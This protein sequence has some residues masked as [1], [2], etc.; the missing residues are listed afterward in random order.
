M[1]VV[2]VNGDVAATVLSSQNRRAEIVSDKVVK[3]HVSK[4]A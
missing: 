4:A 3:C 2:E 1:L